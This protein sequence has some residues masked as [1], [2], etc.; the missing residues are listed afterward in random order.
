MTLLSASNASVD[1]RA[2]RPSRS[3][4]GFSDCAGPAEASGDRA[5][6]ASGLDQRLSALRVPHSP[7]GLQPEPGPAHRARPQSAP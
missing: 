4:C 3:Q 2:G 7:E 6:G 5:R 1:P